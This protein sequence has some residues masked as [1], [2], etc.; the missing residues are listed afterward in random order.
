MQ[1]GTIKSNTV[2]RLSRDR[3]TSAKAYQENSR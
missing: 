3:A 2:R 1:A